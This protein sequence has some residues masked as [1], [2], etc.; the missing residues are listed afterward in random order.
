MRRLTCA[1]GPCYYKHA[2]AQMLQLQLTMQ[3]RP[4]ASQ[5]SE[6]QQGT[7]RRSCRRD[8]TGR[9]NSGATGD[10]SENA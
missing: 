9:S 8:K 4:G 2:A 1:V 5:Q 7:L 6:D 3:P 10:C